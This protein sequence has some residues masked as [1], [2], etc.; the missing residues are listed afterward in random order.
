MTVKHA[1]PG[2]LL[3][4]RVNDTDRPYCIINPNGPVGDHIVAGF[5]EHESEANLF[6]QA[7]ALLDLLTLALPYVETAACDPGYDKA[8]VTRL[9]SRIR[10]TL[11]K[12]DAQSRARA[13]LSAAEQG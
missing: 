5:I 4:R 13:V 2:P 11:S 1:T 9:A 10:D 7:P 3:A 6:A 8:A 12:A